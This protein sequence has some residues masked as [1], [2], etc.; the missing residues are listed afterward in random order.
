MVKIGIGHQLYEL[1]YIT[2]VHIGIAQTSAYHL[3]LVGKEAK[4][5][6]DI[7]G[8]FFTVPV[9]TFFMSN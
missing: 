3:Y 8:S 1:V 9:N 4:R 6:S 2:S 5:L 7:N